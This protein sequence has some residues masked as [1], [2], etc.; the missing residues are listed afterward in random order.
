MQ[1]EDNGIEEGLDEVEDVEIINLMITQEHNLDEIINQDLDKILD[2]W[3]ERRL[4]NIGGKWSSCTDDRDLEENS[5]DDNEDKIT[6]VCHGN[7]RKVKSHKYFNNNI[8]NKMR[9]KD[10]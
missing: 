2:I 9:T 6:G 7:R 8:M 5:E 10:K 3:R 4:Y 1:K